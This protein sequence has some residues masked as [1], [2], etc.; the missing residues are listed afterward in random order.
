M[1]C[2][3]FLNKIQYKYAIFGIYLSKMGEYMKSNIIV[4]GKKL[5]SGEIRISG[6]KNCALCL[7]AGALL[8]KDEVIINNVPDI[9]DVRQFLKILNYLNVKT[10]FENNV[11]TINAK[12]ME[13]KDLLMD[14]V[15]SFRAS[16]YLLGVLLNKIE[17]FKISRF[18]GCNFVKRPINYHRDLFKHFGVDSIESDDCYEFCRRE[19]LYDDYSLTYPSFGTS[20]NAIL[21]A[22]GTNREIHIHNLTSEIEF[23]HFVMF[24]V[25]MG[26]NISLINDTAIIRPSTLHGG[27]FNNIPDRIETGTFMLMGP[28]ICEKIKINN[29]CPAHN[30]ALLDLF[31][32][33]DINY[34]LGNDYIVLE[35]Q[36][37]KKSVF[38][39]TGFNEKISSDLQP[40]LS[41]FCLNIKRISVIKEVVYPSRFTHV[42]PLK[43]MGGFIALSNQNLLINGIMDLYATSVEITDLRMGAA[44]IFASLTASGKSKITNLHYVERGYENFIKKLKCLGADIEEYES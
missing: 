42:E 4:T 14:T 2:F 40:I 32:L 3:Y 6:S 8:I 31:T 39:E 41:V 33:L 26:A 13:V 38:I 34:E 11:L 15:A 24:L 18:G 1:R 5:L 43:D 20:V 16:Y 19:Y 25:N 27:E 23:V 37:I 17:N 22:L 21:Y 9:E 29:I 35:K 36:D 28:I 12:N 44:M 7:I 30:K 10:N